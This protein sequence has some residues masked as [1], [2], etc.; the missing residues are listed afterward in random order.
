MRITG[1]SFLSFQNK[2]NTNKVGCRTQQQCHMMDKFEYLIC[3]ECGRHKD[4]TN[5]IYNERER[6]A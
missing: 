2:C 5:Y 3:F 6:V 1:R 4:N